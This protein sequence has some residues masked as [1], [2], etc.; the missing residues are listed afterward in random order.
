M[1]GNKRD[2]ILNATDRLMETIPADKHRMV[3]FVIIG[4]FV[5]F[6]AIILW[7]SIRSCSTA[8][9]EKPV[10]TKR[11]VQIP[12]DELFLPE[13]PDFVPGV[14]LDREQRTEWTE[15]DVM[16]WWEDPLKGGEDPWRNLIEKTVDEILGGVP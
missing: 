14:M 13:E 7:V 6:L 9:T 1:R 11:A 2:K 15:N 8:N 5:F 4:V 16:P 10:E 3:V 12:P